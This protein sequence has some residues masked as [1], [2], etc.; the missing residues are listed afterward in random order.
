MSISIKGGCLCGAVRY[1]C[2]VAPQTTIICHC[3]DCQKYT[4]TAYAI[5]LL[6]LKDHVRISGELKDFD[7]KTDAGNVMTRTFC[8]ICGT[9]ISKTSTR[10]G[11]HIA[12][13]AGSL[14]DPGQFKPE[15]EYWSDRKLPWVEG[16]KDIPKFEGNPPIV[17]D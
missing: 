9:H 10:S 2:V 1:E 4:G 16:M 13:V 8:M 12:I 15:A 7:S 5:I 6:F 14:D 17:D 11:E 3:T